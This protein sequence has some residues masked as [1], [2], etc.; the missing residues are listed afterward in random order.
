MPDSNQKDFLKTA[1]IL[2]QKAQMRANRKNRSIFLNAGL[3]SVYGFQMVVP[4]LLG[5]FIGRFLDKHF[6]TDSFSWTLNFILLGFILGF[7]SAYK[8]STR[9]GVVKKN[10]KD[11]K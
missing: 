11:K 6:P 3:L 7:I 2:I 10:E 1:E 9:E 5:I 4:V 8:W